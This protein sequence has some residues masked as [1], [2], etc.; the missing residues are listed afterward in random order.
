MARDRFVRW[1][2]GKR[3]QNDVI[4]KALED[5]V[6]GLAEV[7]WVKDR[8]YVT[9]PGAPSWSFQRVGPAEAYQRAGWL[10]LAK[11][12]NGSPRNRWIEVWPGDDCIDVMTRLMDD[13]TNI[14]ADGFATLMGRGFNGQV[15]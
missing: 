1:P 3:P 5:Y 4:Q 2:D 9:L 10:E 6:R 7:E 13:I 11:E 15:E 12:S 14:I 8:W